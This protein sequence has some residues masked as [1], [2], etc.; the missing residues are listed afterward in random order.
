MD[1]IVLPEGCGRTRTCTPPRGT[2]LGV[3]SPSEASPRLGAARQGFT[4]SRVQIPVSYLAVFWRELAFVLRGLSHVSLGNSAVKHHWEFLSGSLSPKLSGCLSATS[5]RP[6]QVRPVR[7]VA[8]WPRL[9]KTLPDRMLCPS[10]QLHAWTLM[11]RTR[12]LWCPPEGAPGGR[13][14]LAYKWKG[15]VGV[16]EERRSGRRG[17][18][19]HSPPPQLHT[20]LV[21]FSATGRVPCTRGLGGCLHHFLPLLLQAL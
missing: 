1:K 9:G 16:P 19:R 14:P 5:A 12:I 21:G 13:G 4:D 8:T 15:P 6:G 10:A 17:S 7:R 3:H 20:R 18:C 11:G 2:F